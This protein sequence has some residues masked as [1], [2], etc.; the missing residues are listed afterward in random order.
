MKFILFILI[1]L[2]FFFWVVICFGGWKEIKVV[3]CCIK[4]GFLL[5]LF[6]GNVELFED[7]LFLSK[8]K[9]GFI[10]VF[11]CFFDFVLD[12]LFFW[13]LVKFIIKFGDGFFKIFDLFLCEWILFFVNCFLFKVKLFILVDIFW[14]KEFSF[15]WRLL[16][17]L[18][19][20]GGVGFLFFI[21]LFSEFF[22]VRFVFLV[23][24]NLLLLMFV[25]DLF[26]ELSFLEVLFLLFKLIEVDI[27]EL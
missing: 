9:G 22:F 24:V 26:F 19:F 14:I 27:D 6:F 16:E 11:E 8:G 21:F 25:V 2:F 12:W 7:I 17:F 3:L 13:V 23:I 4:F 5:V 20:K 10:I 15:F 18:C 1:M